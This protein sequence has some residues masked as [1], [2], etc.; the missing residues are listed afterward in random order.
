MPSSKPSLFELP[1]RAAGPV[2]GILP[3]TTLSMVFVNPCASFESTL[4][5]DLNLDFFKSEYQEIE[6]VFLGG[7]YPDKNDCELFVVSGGKRLRAFSI[8]HGSFVCKGLLV[9]DGCLKS[10]W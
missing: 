8:I 7:E 3:L 4:F 1:Q 9:F 5:G 10:S 2:G 6:F